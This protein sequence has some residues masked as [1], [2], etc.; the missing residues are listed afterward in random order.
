MALITM[1][2]LVARVRQ[3]ADL[4]GSDGPVTDAEI[5]G[6]LVLAI[7]RLYEMLIEARGQEYYRATMEL[8]VTAGQSIYSLPSDFFQL[9]A[10]FGADSRV[11]AATSATFIA[12]DSGN[13]GRWGLLRPFGMLE[14][15]TLLG[16]NRRDQ[17]GAQADRWPR[18]RLRGTQYPAGEA[19]PGFVEQSIELR[20]A[21]TSGWTLRLEYLPAALASTSDSA[22]VQGIN[23]WE[24]VVVLKVAAYCK[25]K[26][27]QD[28]GYLVARVKEETDRIQALAR[29]RDAGSSEPG[30]IDVCGILD[31]P[32]YPGGR[33]PYGGGWLS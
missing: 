7:Q 1:A 14:L 20:P 5:K 17:W 12:S 26:Q 28:V 4:E 10:L 32:A 3:A 24:E 29:A 25:A 13:S 15:G 21:P 31:G 18:Y 2:T 9:L 16:A 8:D 11:M 23:G 6:Q 33:R 22:V 19:P 30:V 27:E